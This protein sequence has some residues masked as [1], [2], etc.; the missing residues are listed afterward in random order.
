LSEK[1]LDE[2]E[3]LVALQLRNMESRVL[4]WDPDDYTLAILESRKETSVTEVEAGITD[5]C[6]SQSENASASP[7]R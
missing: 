1:E 7:I 5:L 3:K 6:I 4:A 2:M